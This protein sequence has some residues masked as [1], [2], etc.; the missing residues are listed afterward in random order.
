MDFDSESNHP[1]AILDVP[2]RQSVKRTLVS[3]EGLER[4]TGIQSL[5]AKHLTELAQLAS[6][7]P[8]EKAVAQEA[9]QRQKDVEDARAQLEQARGATASVEKDLARLR[10]DAKAVGDRGAAAQPLVARIVAAEDRLTALRKRT[11]GLEKDVSARVE[12]VRKVL[13]RLG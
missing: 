10:E 6:L 1:I 2:S 8:A 7:P 9:A 4:R 11:E 3:V 13:A 5:S 12:A